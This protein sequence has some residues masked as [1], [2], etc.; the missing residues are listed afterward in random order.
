[1]E[2]RKQKALALAKTEH[3]KE[4]PKKEKETLDEQ[5]LKKVQEMNKWMSYVK[6]TDFI[7]V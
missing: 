1:M 7:Y 5:V 6:M 2:N 4:E 3:N